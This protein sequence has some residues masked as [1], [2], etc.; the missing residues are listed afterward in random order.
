MMRKLFTGLAMCLVVVGM[1]HAASPV[2][3]GLVFHLEADAITGVA[4]DGLIAGW[5][6]TVG[7]DATIAG[8]DPNFV[9]DAINGKP[10]VNF[11]GG[12][13]LKFDRMT[14][15]R[16]VFWV[17]KEDVDAS[18]DGFLLGDGSAY[19]FHRNTGGT[20]EIWSQWTSANVIN[21][22]TKIDGSQV[23][24]TVTD[25]PNSLS[26]ISVVT[27]GNV[28]ASSFSQDRTQPATRRWDGLLSELL[29]FDRPLSAGEENEVGY[30]L[31]TK[32]GFTTSYT[33]PTVYLANQSPADG[34]QRIA[35]DVELTWDVKVA[36]G[37]P[38]YTVYFG[39][40]PNTAGAPVATTQDAFY[41]A[42]AALAVATTYYWRVDV[43]DDSNTTVGEILSFTTGGDI[44]NLLPP[45]GGTGSA[46]DVTVSWTA[47]AEGATYIDGYDIYFGETLPVTPTATLT[48]NQWQSPEL[49]DST[50]Y[51]CKVVSMHD[52]SPVSE[53]AVINFTT[54][55]IVG[56]WPFD[57][58]LT[59]I[60]GGRD[61]S[62]AN[63]HWAPGFIEDGTAAD[64]FGDESI[65][66]P[67][68]GVAPVSNWT[69]TL[70]EYSYAG[71]GGW[72]SILGNG[73]DPDGWNTFEFGRYNGN[74]YIWGTAGGGYKATANDSSFL[75]EGW[76]FHVLSYD[77]DA[78]TAHWYVD[79]G[80]VNTYPG[81]NMTLAPELYVGNVKGGSQPFVG[82]VDDLKFF[83]RPLSSGQA[84]QS[85]IDGVDGAPIKPNP[86]SGTP[87]IAWDVVLEW[88]MVET[89]TSMTIEVGKLAD[90]SD[91]T[92]IA[93][94]ADATSFDVIAGLGVKLAPST[95]Y[96]WRVTATYPDKTSAGPTWFFVVR[97]LLG[98]LDD[99]L[100]VNID[101]L[102][103]FS[104]KWL[105]DTKDFPPAEYAYL[106][107][108]NWADPNFPDEDPQL[109]DY[110][111][112][113]GGDGTTWAVGQATL[114]TNPKP[115][116]ENHDP[117]SH[118]MLW[119]YDS[120]QGGY[121]H[122][123][124][125]EL[126]EVMDFSEFDKFGYWVYQTSTSG[127]AD[128]RIDD[129]GD[130]D[131]YKDWYDMSTHDGQ[132]H[133]YEWDMPAN[134]PTEVY[135]IRFYR[136]DASGATEEMSDFFLVKDGVATKLCL[137]EFKIHE[138]DYNKDCMI[139]FLDFVI[140]A[141]DWL[142]DASN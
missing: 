56:H 90:L 17:V 16:T 5:P 98:D 96:F 129:N 11:A 2:T 118:T 131:I 4:D 36:Q 64:F 134:A 138:E 57:D 140:M 51:Q 99:N 116:D 139:D 14:N 66:V 132:W 133:K 39:E 55:A 92:P 78:K 10:A 126:P 19:H 89:P 38:T 114:K 52:G 93:L 103:Q 122:G 15:I 76:H 35:Q 81:A 85:Y 83:S 91:A 49:A 141:Q 23:D 88:T 105:T 59:D 12:A 119:S 54:G 32:Y 43:S 61:G 102:G 87:D 62:R 82:K 37:T 30:Y 104:A 97:D 72:E 101:D 34:A 108:E 27:T 58:N 135:Q 20:G 25:P 68:A 84:L 63:P 40:D 136:G 80:L 18:K 67:T 44:V 60:V 106:N 7:N 28:T 94:A 53:S 110:A 86:L 21:G 123:I 70:W 130:N 74:R 3:D 77:N 50:A 47:E 9:A 112:P 13:Y 95:G 42:P 115:A 79:G 113:W 121:A 125:I 31:A 124:T 128:I 73:P 1:A 41:T 111:V 6:A 142:L 120:S 107:H 117:G 100:V 109:T 65:N 33:T 137:N 24:G 22:V 71:G 29:V 48:E 75:R 46:T 127:S 69:I 8:G 26:I 45:D